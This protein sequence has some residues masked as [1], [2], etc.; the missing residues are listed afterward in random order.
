MKTSLPLLALVA[1]TALLLV[2]VLVSAQQ[3]PNPPPIWPAQFKA[4][5]G[6][7]QLDTPS[8]SPIF[9]ETSQF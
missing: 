2:V 8:E 3:A 4:N 7:Y 9:N 5:F 1:S 6:L